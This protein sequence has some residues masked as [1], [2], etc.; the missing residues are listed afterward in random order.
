MA[1]PHTT[2]SAD[3]VFGTAISFT[4]LPEPVIFDENDREKDAQYFFTLAA[5]DKDKHMENME[6]LF[7]FLTMDNVLDELY[8]IGNLSDLKNIAQQIK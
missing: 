1:M 2:I 7:T 5:T 4:R 8:K 3:G 6:K